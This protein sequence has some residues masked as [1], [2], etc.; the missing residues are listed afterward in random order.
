[1]KCFSQ[2]S[3]MLDESVIYVGFT[4]LNLANFTKLDLGVN[5]RTTHITR[6]RDLY[7]SFNPEVPAKIF[8]TGRNILCQ[9]SGNEKHQST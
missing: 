1:M 7:Q 4:F 9:T 6:R 5:Q 2:P 3:Q 8:L